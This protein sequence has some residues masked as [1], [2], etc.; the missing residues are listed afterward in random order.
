MVDRWGSRMRSITETDLPPKAKEMQIR[1]REEKL[2]R[3]GIANI[4]SGLS[5]SL[6]QGSGN[7]DGVMEQVKRLEEEKGKGGVKAMIEKVWMGS[8][9]ED[10]KKKRDEREKQ[11]LEEGRGY[12][13]LIVDQIWEVWNWGEKKVEQVKEE[14]LKALKGN[15][16]RKG[17]K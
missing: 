2:R 8:E 5:P 1:L 15:D 16:E 6:S 13:G 11:A 12:G 7:N 17:G 3:E 14:D 4:D 9:G 10:W